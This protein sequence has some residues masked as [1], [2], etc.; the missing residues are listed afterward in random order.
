LK[1][2]HILF[3]PERGVKNILFLLVKGFLRPHEQTLPTLFQAL[4]G[5]LSNSV[6]GSY[7]PPRWPGKK[8]GA[9][10][11]KGREKPCQFPFLH[12]R[13]EARRQRDSRA[14]TAEARIGKRGN[15]AF[16]GEAN[17]FLP[18]QGITCP[19]GTVFFRKTR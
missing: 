14:E 17:A 15:T 13:K 19:K 1:P 10:G 2:L 6:G 7:Q 11:K 5:I 9:E 12:F 8:S 3:D 16:F 18:G 4:I